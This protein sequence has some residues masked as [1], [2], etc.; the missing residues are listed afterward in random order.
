MLFAPGASSPRATTKLARVAADAAQHCSL[1]A[2]GRRGGGPQFG[3]RSDN[4]VLY[5]LSF[6]YL[7]YFLSFLRYKICT[8]GAVV[9]ALTS[10]TRAPE[11]CQFVPF[12]AS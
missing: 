1:T 6:L 10:A 11:S 7:I 4:R 8:S 2:A 12:N 9:E 3:G 5:F